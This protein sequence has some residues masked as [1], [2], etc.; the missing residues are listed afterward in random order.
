MR[1][2]RIGLAALVLAAAVQVRA[3][4]PAPPAYTAHC[5]ACHGLDRLGGSGPA[6]LPENLERLR[7]PAAAETIAKGRMATQMPA[8]TDKLSAAD[9]DALVAYIYA[10]PATP[11]VWGEREIA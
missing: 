8:F 2:L 7:K 11:P 3:E 10:P 6:L 5:A 9:I 1:R 4:V